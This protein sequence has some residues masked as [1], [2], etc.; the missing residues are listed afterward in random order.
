MSYFNITGLG[1]VMLTEWNYV[2]VESA[3]LN[4]GSSQ[5]HLLM[6]L[7]SVCGREALCDQ[8]SFW[9]QFSLLFLAF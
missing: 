7:L 3:R 9:L 1:I 2:H 5:H 8:F 4:S 6:F